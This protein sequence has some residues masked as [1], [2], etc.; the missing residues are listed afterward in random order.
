MENPKFIFPKPDSFARLYDSLRSKI[1]L[2]A[3]PDTFIL[4]R[5]VANL[6]P[7]DQ[8]EIIKK[9]KA[10]NEF[11]EDIDPHNEH[12]LIKVEHKGEYY[13]LKFDWYGG[14]EGYRVVIT[15]MNVRDY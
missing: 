3:K 11:T 10:F 12:D 9:T 6:D 7:S 2:I 5:T 4:T 15:L 13:Y 1:P 8:A 14:Q